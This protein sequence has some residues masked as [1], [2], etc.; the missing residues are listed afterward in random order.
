MAGASRRPG[1]ARLAC[2]AAALAAGRPGPALMT[3]GTDPALGAGWAGLAGVAGVVCPAETVLV[4][5]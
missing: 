3:L 2:P 5:G 4:A 1:R